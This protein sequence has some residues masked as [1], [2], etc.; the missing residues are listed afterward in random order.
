MI[1]PLL[2]LL[3]ACALLGASPAASAKAVVGKT[4]PAFSAKDERGK[5]HT[6]KQYRGKI[7]VLEWTNPGCPFVKRHYLK[8]KTMHDTAMRYLRRKF[9]RVVWLAV[10]SSYFNKPADSKK[11]TKARGLP[12]RTLQDPAGTIGRAYG[13]K[14]TPH[15]FVIDGKGV[16]RY[17]GAIDDDPHDEKKKPTNYVDA[18]LRAL[19]RGKAPK[20]SSSAPYGCTVKYKR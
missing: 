14:S 12:Y 9:Q 6:L 2:S 5:T 15:M 17:A 11:W 13:A 1:R 18:A 19:T 4:A 10:N 7:V 3:L 20:V 8:K 16:V